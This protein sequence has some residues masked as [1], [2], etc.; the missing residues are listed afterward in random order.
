MPCHQ[1]N[2]S[3]LGVAKNLNVSKKREWHVGEEIEHSWKSK[4]TPKATPARNNPWT[5]TTHGKMKVL[6]P[7]Y[8][9]CNP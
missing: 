1:L 5:P 9:G 8:M 4:A 3:S 7:Q 2:V 6:N